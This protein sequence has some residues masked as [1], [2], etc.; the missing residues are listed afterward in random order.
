MLPHVGSSFRFARRHQERPSTEEYPTPGSCRRHYQQL[1]TNAGTERKPKHRDMGT[2]P[3]P[4]TK[5]RTGTVTEQLYN[6]V[7][8]S[9][10]N[11]KNGAKQNGGNGQLTREKGEC[12]NAPVGNSLKTCTIH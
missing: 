7:I 5:S 9:T 2:K 4:N 8:V 10:G 12:A 3:I 1:Y 6:A 11:W